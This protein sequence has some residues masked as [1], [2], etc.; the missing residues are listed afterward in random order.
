MPTIVDHAL[1]LL[2]LFIVH[3]QLRCIGS[4][5]SFFASGRLG[6]TVFG[7]QLGVRPAISFNQANDELF[8]EFAPKSGHFH[9]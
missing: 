6:Y 2:S 7:N 5:R 4:L 8:L 9:T 1:L 3:G